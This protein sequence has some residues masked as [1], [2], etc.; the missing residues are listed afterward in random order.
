MKVVNLEKIYK[1]CGNADKTQR[2]WLQ[3]TVMIVYWQGK[4]DTNWY[5]LKMAWAFVKGYYNPKPIYKMSRNL[6]Y[7][8]CYEEFQSGRYVGD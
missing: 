2:Y 7:S 3:K 1:Y 6:T 8:D 4:K 5:T